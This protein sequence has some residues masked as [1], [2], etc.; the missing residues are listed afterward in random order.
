VV[1]VILRF[2]Q[3]PELR[4]CH[5]IWLANDTSGST[6]PD[7]LAEHFHGFA[8][9]GRFCRLAVAVPVD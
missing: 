6:L 5:P 4:Q 7:P 1:N 8:L 2:G 9:D 3:T